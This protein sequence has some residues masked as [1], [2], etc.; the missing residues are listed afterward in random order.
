MANLNDYINA[1]IPW[2]VAVVGIY[3]L[4]RPLRPIL[5]PLFHMIGN[6][7]GWIKSKATGEEQENAG[8][9]EY[10]KSVHYE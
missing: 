3:I 1:I 4:Y 9:K 6:V 8:W 2:V 7:L 10:Y 5:E